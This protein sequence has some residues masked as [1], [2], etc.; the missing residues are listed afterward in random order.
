MLIAETAYC[1]KQLHKTCDFIYDDIQTLLLQPKLNKDLNEI[2]NCL[3]DYSIIKHLREEDCYNTN[4]YCT[5]SHLKKYCV[6]YQKKKKKI[7]EFQKNLL[8]ICCLAP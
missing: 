5:C 3:R 1:L 2:V 6:N 7:C 4:I 8:E